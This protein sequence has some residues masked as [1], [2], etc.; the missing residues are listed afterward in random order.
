MLG[1]P[2]ISKDEP[3]FAIGG[4]ELSARSHDGDDA[5]ARDVSFG[6]PRKRD[7][8]GAIEPDRRH[9]TVMGSHD[10]KCTAELPWRAL[11]REGL[12][13]LSEKLFVDAHP[14]ASAW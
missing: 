14:E 13:L 8:C 1:A 12:R 6:V 5:L 2:R 7:L 4:D 11:R 3:A 10:A 9:G